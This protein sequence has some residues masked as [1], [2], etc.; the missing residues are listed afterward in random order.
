MLVELVALRKVYDPELLL[1]CQVDIWVKRKG[2][3]QQYPHY[4]AERTR[5]AKVE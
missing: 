3:P 5:P 4:G 2:W 1:R